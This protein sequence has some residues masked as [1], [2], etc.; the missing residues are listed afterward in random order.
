VGPLIRQ[1]LED[2]KALACDSLHGHQWIST[3]F[4]PLTR[5]TN[6]KNRLLIIDG[7]SSHLT[8]RFL[9]L[10]IIKSI[11]LCLLPPYTSHVTQPLNLSVF[12]P[13]KTYLGAELD[14]I[15]RHSTSRITRVEFTAA[16][17]QA[18]ERIFR[19]HSI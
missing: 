1:L 5:R 14:R 19:P 18:R 16:Y 2:S 17:I 7:Y 13:L 15:F 6:G 12:G 11:D 4:E 10:Y 9:A 3:R 8:A